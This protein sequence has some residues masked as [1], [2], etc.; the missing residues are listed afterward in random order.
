MANRREKSE[1]RD[2]FYF[3]GLLNCGDCSREIKRCLLLGKKAVT[4]L[5]SIIKSR[6]LTLPTKICT[7]K[8][9][10]FAVVTCGCESWT[11][12]KVEHQRIDAF[13]IV[14]LEKT[15]ESP[16]DSK[17]I[18]PVDLKGNQSWYS[19][20]GLMLKAQYFGHLMEKSWLF[21]KYPDTGED[22]R[23]KEKGGSRGWDGNI[24]SPVQCTWI[25]TNFGKDWRTGRPGV[26]QPMGSQ[27][28]G[29]NLVT[30]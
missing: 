21:G 20:E 7:F 15:L 16:L 26:L 12:K 29:H 14:V 10:V 6:D 25:W 4:N 9:M 19:L 13:E 2:R 1:N 23:Q 28:V 22:W 5:N 3:L 8:P 17:G 27:R 18:Q 11:L 24:A 30:E